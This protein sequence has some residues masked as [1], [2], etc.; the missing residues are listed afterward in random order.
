MDPIPEAL[1]QALQEAGIKEP[2]QLAEH[3]DLAHDGVFG[4]QWIVVTDRQILI[5]HREKDGFRIVPLVALDAIESIDA[6]ELAGAG[7]LEAVVDG[8]RVRLLSYSDARGAD[9]Q[10]L[11]WE[12]DRMRGV[13]TDA[14]PESRTRVLCPTCAKPLPPGF[15]RCPRCTPRSHTFARLL[16]FAKPHRALILLVLLLTTI[17]TIFGLAVPFISK[18]FID[19]VFKQDPATGAF[20]FKHW[21]LPAVG[22]LFLAYAAQTLFAGLQ[23]R[24]SGLVGF[25]TV[26][27]LRAALYERIQDLS[28]SFFDSH[29]TGAIMARVNQD[30]AELQRLMVDFIPM[31][32]DCVLLLLG[33]G[34]GLFIL[35][36]RLTLCVIIPIGAV[37]AFMFMVIPR[38]HAMF[39]HY[40]RQEKNT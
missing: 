33:V 19:Y 15:T 6:V 8:K 16:K 39:K 9:F 13:N 37:V 2:I 18:V 32:L 4:E 34:T 3:S 36:W 40:F 14:E 29:H 5:A 24:V 17:G 35:S 31:S 20:L 10:K 22:L 25:R 28:L 38:I 1:Q 23:E 21:H 11:K 26:Y 12:L 7:V 27:D 30:T